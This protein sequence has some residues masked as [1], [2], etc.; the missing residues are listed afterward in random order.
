MPKSLH[1]KQ[2]QERRGFVLRQDLSN[3]NTE[4]PNLSTIFINV[5]A[6]EVLQSLNEKNHLL[7]VIRSPITSLKVSFSFW[8]RQQQSHPHLSEDPL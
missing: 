1:D 6:L 8:I 7:H 3:T 2:T 4:F 5:F